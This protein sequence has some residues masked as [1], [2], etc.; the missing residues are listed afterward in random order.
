MEQPEEQATMRGYNSVES[1][2]GPSGIMADLSGR[3]IPEP[4]CYMLVTV[5]L[6]Y[7]VIFVT[8]I[9]GNSLVI[10]VLWRNQAMRSYTNCLLGN[11]SIA[12]LLVILVCMPTAVLDL[13]AKEVWYL[14]SA[15]C[16]YIPRSPVITEENQCPLTL[17]PCD[18]NSTIFTVRI[19]LQAVPCKHK[20]FA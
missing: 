20:T 8:G 16:K 6:L 5:T 4:P 19:K 1:T 7:I 9:I 2:S 3:V 17:T 15:M 13:H 10:V 12:D 18:Q 11:L 14:G